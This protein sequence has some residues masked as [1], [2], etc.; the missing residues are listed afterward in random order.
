MDAGVG[1]AADEDLMGLADR[2]ELGQDGGGIAVQGLELDVEAQVAGLGDQGFEHVGVGFLDF[3]L[4]LA[5]G[6]L[7]RGGG[8]VAAGGVGEHMDD[9]EAGAGVPGGL[10][11]EVEGAAA[12]FAAVDADR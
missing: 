10:G 7:G 4:L 11:G 9:E 12:A 3:L 5:E 2:S 6:E 8:E 1:L